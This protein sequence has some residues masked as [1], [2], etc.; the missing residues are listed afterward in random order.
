MTRLYTS[1]IR[2]GLSDLLHA[3]HRDV[4]LAC[5]FIKT[6]EIEWM[7]A[8]LSD[9][10]LPD[11]RFCLI[12]DIRLENVLAGSLDLQGLMTLLDSHTHNKV[13]NLPRLHAKVYIA[14]QAFA[15][16]TSGNLTHSGLESNHEY[17]I[18]ITTTRDVVKIRRDIEG[19]ANLGNP[20]SKAELEKL[21]DA[22]KNV[23]SD[24]DSERKDQ[25][26]RLRKKLGEALRESEYEF[27]KA[28]V[29]Q[30]SA[31]NLF[32]QVILY[33]LQSG[34]FTTPEIHEKVKYVFPELCDDDRE[35]IING[36]A[37]GKKWKHTVRT[38]Q[39]HL[40]RQ[41]QIELTDKRWQLC[42]KN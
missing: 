19:Y 21:Q 24:F 35:L 7:L 36:E 18:G 41:G 23:Q 6:R 15:L 9:R 39:A 13:I 42:G 40:K 29:G 30:R 16:V 8:Q 32:A 1:P 12:T 11:V 5:P 31:H 17:G 2:R 10:N 14:D 26:Q 4:L 22:V 38:A 27:L 34:S 33:V 20:I 37:F 28:Q 3:A 25:S